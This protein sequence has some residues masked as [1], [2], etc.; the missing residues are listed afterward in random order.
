MHATGRACV[1]CYELA[2]PSLVTGVT[3][4]PVRACPARVLERKG[5]TSMPKRT[6]LSSAASTPMAAPTTVF[7]HSEGAPA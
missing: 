4:R 3:A 1:T 5:D 7:S 2:R 6:R